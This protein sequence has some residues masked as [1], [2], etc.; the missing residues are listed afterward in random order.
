[1]AE[2]FD[3]GKLIS[4]FNPFRGKNFGK[5]IFVMVIASFVIALAL[6]VYHKLTQ[7]T[8]SMTIGNVE[9]GGT[10][11]VNEPLDEKLNYI[12]A[13]GFGNQDEQSGL[14]FYMRKF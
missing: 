8:T 1:M 13:G 7:E 3:V 9:S 4:G 10:V 2:R 14:V 12:G 6:G 11:I 5:I